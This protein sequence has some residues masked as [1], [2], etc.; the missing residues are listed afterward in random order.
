MRF[1]RVSYLLLAGVL[2]LQGGMTLPQ[3]AAAERSPRQT[4]LPSQR[5]AQTAPTAGICTAQLGSAIARVIDR[6]TVARSR[7]GILIQTQ[8]PNSAQQ[9][10]FSRNATTALIPASNNKI[11]TTA[12]A[13]RQLGAQHRFHTTVTGNGPTATVE[14]L[15][16]MGQGDP[17]LTTQHLTDLSQ[18]LQQKG[19]QQVNL[20]IGDDTY[21][22]GSA[23]NPY[24]D[25]EDTLAGYGAPVNSLI[26]NQN[27][28]GLTLF[29]T[30]LGQP[31]RVEWGDPL[32]ATDWKVDNQTTT[33]S[34]QASEYI[35]G[36][37]VPGQWL[38]RVSGQLRVGSESEFVAAAIPNP[39]NY[40]VQRFRTVL[41]QTGIA[42]KQSTLVKRTPAPPGEV[43][44]AAVASPPLGQLL[45]ETNQESNN[46]FAEVLLKTLG[47]LQTPTTADPTRSGV[48][49]VQNI[50]APLGV[51]PA[52]YSMVD[53]S[54]LADRNRATPQALVQTL[55][56]MAQIPEAAVF[57]GSLPIAGVS[58]TLKNRFKNTA[59]QGQ[60]A[61]KTGTISGVVALSGYYTPPAYP[62]LVF[63][64][65][66][67]DGSV[68]G[69]SLRRTVD[70]V[71]LLLPR[72]RR[73]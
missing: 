15:R 4:A 59:L 63:S 2:G 23:I 60:L 22:Q 8:G 42:V 25:P 17:S 21:F 18:Q 67:N 61:A 54:G 5:V 52:G 10:L 30:R 29:P 27:A 12:A 57:R 19:I 46:L 65:L 47:R 49:A 28:I 39:G 58:G 44:L 68:S 56:A 43:T 14:T 69:A 7:W 37:R 41:G 48:A 16:I 62:P 24:W 20:L 70:E 38:V 73:C 33:V 6:S 72:L 55:Q 11:F 50:L 66:V 51:A 71:V 36:V 13:L 45:Q 9:T 40:L 32:D 31:L 1:H 35:D 3:V 34:A 64:I 53:G 26:L